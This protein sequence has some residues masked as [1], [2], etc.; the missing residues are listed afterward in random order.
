MNG[1][2]GNGRGN[3]K[4]QQKAVNPPTPPPA[5]PTARKRRDW[6]RNHEKIRDAFLRLIEAKKRPTLRA[7]AKEAGFNRTTIE[8]HIDTLD[9]LQIATAPVK[10]LGEEILLS[11]G[12]AALRTG[13]AAEAKL[14]MQLVYGWREQLDLGHKNIPSNIDWRKVKTADLERIANGA[15]IG[16][17]LSTDN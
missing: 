2:N 9:V 3:G 1:K 6:E 13:R 10:M 7:L 15:D 11:L 4:S 14:Y 5:P 17:V 12:R 8:K 16:A